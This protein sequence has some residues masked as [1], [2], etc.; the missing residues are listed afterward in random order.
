[1]TSVHGTIKTEMQDS[2]S[3][4]VSILPVMTAGHDAENKRKS[5]AST[6]HWLLYQRVIDRRETQHNEKTSSS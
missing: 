4:T 2:L 1:M 6:R 5:L 3:R